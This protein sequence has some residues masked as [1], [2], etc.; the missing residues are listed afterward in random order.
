L[1]Q[2]G[3]VPET[4]KKVFKIHRSKNVFASASDR[5]GGG[6][7]LRP[8]E[9][10]G[11]KLGCIRSLRYL[12]AGTSVGRVGWVFQGLHDGVITEG[13]KG[14]GKGNWENGPLGAIPGRG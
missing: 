2:A 6:G 3:K 13:V 9:P 14:Q 12:G 4:P 8:G 11:P 7:I 5:R 10:G 1:S